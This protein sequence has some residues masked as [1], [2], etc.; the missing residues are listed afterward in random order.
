MNVKKYIN[1]TVTYKAIFTYEDGYVLVHF[2]DYNATTD[3]KDFKD[4][5]D[6]AIDLLELLYMYREECGEE[7]PDISGL[8]DVT[9]KDNQQIVGIPI[10][11]EIAY[12]NY[13]KR[14]N[15]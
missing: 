5:F 6:M 3:G 10:N 11:L 9:C 13:V 7:Q 14:N 15:L 8:D 12:N 4:A 1:R 2:P